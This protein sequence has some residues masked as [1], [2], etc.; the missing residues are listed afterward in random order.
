MLAAALLLA[1]TAAPASAASTGTVKMARRLAEHA[2]RVRRDPSSSPF[3][4]RARAQALRR[5]LRKAAPEERRLLRLELA[6]ELLNAGEAA[7]AAAILDAELTR[8]VD[9]FSERAARSL[10]A[11]AH[12][13]RGEQENCVARHNPSSCLFPIRGAGVHERREG[14]QAAARVLEGMLSEEPEDLLAR[15]LLNVAHM[16]LGSYPDGVPGRWRLS[17]E[18]FAPE[19]D[20]PR[21][22]EGGA[23]AGVS[24]RGIAGGVIMDDFDGDGLLDLMSS[25]SRPGDPLRLH[26][27]RGG[28]VFRDASARLDLPGITGG[29]N[30]IQADYDNDGRLDAL[31]LRGGWQGEG[32]R[33]P[34]SLLRN[35][36]GGRFE[37]AT[38]RAGLLTAAPTQTAVWD[39]FDRDGRLDLFVGFESRPEPGERAYPCALFRGTGDGRF[40]DVAAEAGA[41]VVGYFKGAASG[42]Y[43][44]DGW[45]DLYLSRLDGPNILLR[46]R[47]DGGFEDVTLKAG[48]A[49]PR[50]SF[51]TWFW[52]YDNDGRLDL[53]V[54]G[55]D[56]FLALSPR[57][58]RD[59]SQGLPVAAHTAADYF[60][61]PTGGGRPRLYRNEGDGTFSDRTREAG[62]ARAL[63][64][65]GG[66]FGDLDNDGWPDIYLGTG[67]PDLRALV[68]N[69]AFRGV[70]GKAFRDVTTAAGL[71]DLQKGHGI[72]IGDLRGGGQADV[73]LVAGGLYEGD[74]AQSKLFLNPGSGN[75]WVQLTLEGV[76]S[77]RSAI[78]ARVRAVVDDPAGG[79]R[80]IHAVVSSGGSFGASPLRRHLGLGKAER[81]RRLEVRWPSGLLQGFDDV[82]ARRGYRLREGDAA[83]S[84]R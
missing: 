40:V 60:G 19:Q 51:T 65:M 24:A 56:G 81:V 34:M 67:A 69:R 7:E 1:L 82:A 64:V 26:L 31:V 62:L 38:E 14:A 27:N 73:F 17:P 46:N 16:T 74:E 45:P 59:A 9:A 35:L 22:P 2:E 20:F 50:S 29:L 57:W 58:A 84:A 83:L 3:A 52:D 10:L 11:A 76:R 8:R 18:A 71:G 33:Q 77:N 48:V 13:R 23:A 61:R 72:A 30:L 55:W 44:G 53:F 78:G 32:G 79:T 37:D 80:E 15:W 6:A 43:D 66:N 5:R 47:G 39:D 68:P 70:E 28:G 49:A 36:G 41:A 21:F 75:A 4:N 63:F 25:S 12:L 42:D 54:G